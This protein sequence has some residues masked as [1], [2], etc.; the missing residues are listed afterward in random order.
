ML[1]SS[2]PTLQYRRDIDG[3][4]AIAVLAVV[5]FHAFPYWI[6]GGFIG[7]DIFFVISGYLI[8][9]ILFSSLE[10]KDF[11]FFEFY[12]RR[13]RR[14]FPA[15]ILVLIACYG[16]GWFALLADEYTQLGKHVAGGA[17]FLSNFI[18]LNESGYFDNSAETKPLLHLWSLAVEEQ[19][20][21]FWPFILWVFHKK[22]INL[23]WP[24]ALLLGASLSW[25][26]IESGRNLEQAFYSPLTRFWEL[27]S[28]S[29]L[30][31]G[32][33]YRPNSLSITPIFRPVWGAKTKGENSPVGISQPVLN[34]ISI[35][36]AA[37]L[38]GG[39]WGIGKDIG[40]PGKW[41]LIPVLG[42]VFLIAAGPQSWVNRVVLSC[43]I[44]VWFGLISFPL[45]LW[46]WPLLS[47]AHI[48]CVDTPTVPVR[49][50]I[51]AV[52][53]LFAWLTYRFM[54]R[55]IRFGKTGR[56][57]VIFLAGVL[58]AVGAVG[59]GTYAYGGF[60]FRLKD[61]NDFA[62][63]F[64]EQISEW[65]YPGT[66]ATEAYRHQCNFLDIE[67]HRIEHPKTTPRTALPPECYVRDKAFPKSV[68]L[69]GDSHA[70][71][72]YYGLSR[73]L[74]KDWQIL[75]V[76]TSGCGVN[77]NKIDG[78][79]WSETCENA[80]RFA[81]QAI[82]DAKPDIVI[83]SQFDPLT[84]EEAITYN[85][86]LRALG[87]K[88]VLFVGQDPRW[89]VDLPK[90]VTRN[91]FLFTPRHTFIGLNKDALLKSYLDAEAYMKAG[92]AY[93]SLFSVLCNEDGCLTYLGEDRRQG[94]T[95][96]DSSHLLPI[97]S[98]YVA[99]NLLVPLIYKLNQEE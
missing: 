7:V 53:I 70:Q 45:Y 41:A 48:L 31:W 93:A 90:L 1:L 60:G 39:F 14:I 12:A 92:L 25:N 32:V 62:Q 95:T 80:N 13:V 57:T 74:S 64:D 76:A 10:Q 18:L 4:R 51:V 63:Y 26:L 88:K 55:P 33:L 85:R 66:P 81:R 96:H 37:L 59:Y 22:G 34:G 91:F 78:D 87:A 46:H 35:L 56:R 36:G 67:K 24:V 27:M 47:Y 29:A 86:Q 21:I 15:L 79:V 8:S 42:A 73:D 30:A 52:S 44:L 68:F 82:G 54:E 9:S 99:K 23:F 89:N 83:I 11:G 50:A 77:K 84:V 20:Y 49:F 5:A 65:K 3:L 28:G 16:F 6:R 61:R 40:F 75:Q 94:L 72:L 71:Q 97:A 19:F 69:W 58:L 43:P 2:R 38:I 98:E 17:A